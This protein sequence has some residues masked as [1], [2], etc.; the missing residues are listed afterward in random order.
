MV[1][2]AWKQES[3]SKMA[4]KWTEFTISQ[5]SLSNKLNRWAGKASKNAESQINHPHKWRPAS[6]P[7]TLLNSLGH[8]LARTWSGK[9]TL[10]TS[11]MSPHVLLTTSYNNH[12]KYVVVSNMFLLSYHCIVMDACSMLQSLTYYIKNNFHQPWVIHNLL[13]MHECKRHKW[14]ARDMIVVSAESWS[15]IDSRYWRGILTLTND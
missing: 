2:S 6:P 3:Q 1:L 11:R 12:L 4:S 14:Q 15:L 8:P 10:D 5:S 9:L 13:T 7:L